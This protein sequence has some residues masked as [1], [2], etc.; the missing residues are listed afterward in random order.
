MA[1]HNSLKLITFGQSV[2]PF[3]SKLYQ[4][5]A[6]KL[7]S[8]YDTCSFRDINSYVY[9]NYNQYI[10]RIVVPDYALYRSDSDNTYVSQTFISKLPI[11]YALFVVGY[12]NIE[13]NIGFLSEYAL[14]LNKKENLQIV[15]TV[16]QLWSTIETANCITK[17][18]TDCG[19]SCTCIIP[20]SVHE[21]E[22]L[23]KQS[24]LCLSQNLHALILA[25]KNQIPSFALNDR[26]KFKAFCD[27]TDIPI[28]S[29]INFNIDKAVK[30]TLRGKE[31]LIFKDFSAT[32]EN[33][34]LF[35]M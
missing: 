7:L 24:C 8:M 30:Y 19:V 4:D 33:D 16:S 34:F 12:D 3:S 28:F 10:H 2:G 35:H 6:E 26:T 17:Q 31:G 27:Y 5:I 18:L 14:Y 13:N 29:I 32:I 23:I 1:K 21:L 22:Y 15:F 9:A 25:Y 20:T 11:R